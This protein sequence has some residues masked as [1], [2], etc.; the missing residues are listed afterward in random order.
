LQH[1]LTPEMQQRTS[2]IRQ[3]IHFLNDGVGSK[4]SDA[5]MAGMFLIGS[6]VTETSIPCLGRVFSRGQSRMTTALFV[7]G[8]I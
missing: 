3:S 7:H 8:M 2:S 6:Y 4:H 1:L 5:M